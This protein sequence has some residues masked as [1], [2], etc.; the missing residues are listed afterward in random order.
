MIKKGK[1]HVYTDADNK[2]T[3]YIHDEELMKTKQ[4]RTNYFK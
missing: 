3:T 2:I 1:K 4:D